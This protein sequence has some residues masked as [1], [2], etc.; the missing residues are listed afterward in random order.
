[1]V[2]TIQRYLFL[3]LSALFISSSAFANNVAVSNVTMTGQDASND[4]V[5]VEFDTSWENSWRTSSAPNNWDAVWVFV[6]YK[7]GSGDWQHA[8]LSATASQH[9]APS[10][11]TI[12]PS[13]DG[14]GA[15]IYR[16]ADG[17]GTVS[18]SDAR[19]RWNY[20]TD[21]VADDAQVTLNAI[22]TEMVY[23]PQGSFSLGSGGV[24]TSEF[25]QYPTTPGTYAVSSENVITVGSNTNNL[26]YSS[27]ASGGDRLGTITAAFPKGYNAFYC[28]KYAI[29]QEQ[30]VDFLKTLDRT[31]QNT[32]TGT[33]LASGITSVTNRYVVSNTSSMVYRNGIR[34]DATIPA[35]GTITFYCDY[36]GNGIGGD[37]DD[38]LAIACNCLSWAD[39]A[40][41]ADWAALRPMTELEF[42]KAC[43]GTAATVADEYA[44]GS[45]SITQATGITNSGAGN[46]MASNSSAN[47]V[48]ESHASVQGPMRVGCFATSNSTRETAGATYY[49]IMEMSGNLVQ[50]CVTIGNV[51][52]RSFTGSHGDGV[53]DST[54]NADA[55]SWPSASASGT[56]YRGGDWLSDATFAR[57]SDRTYASYQNDMRFSTFGF[58]CVRL[59][60]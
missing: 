9:T 7:V 23:V 50:R 40:A 12:T 44:W 6:K 41:Y 8:T 54:G 38:G 18:L 42:E 1:M 53:L 37:F 13:S 43:R 29:T 57:V 28:M 19:L 16:S 3:A 20:G 49:G 17:S 34:C 47:S 46:E 35:T 48:Y 58:R 5:L 30:Y 27:S 14:K 21:G 24:G 15:F 36:N 33:N 59:A 11:S 4:Y 10:G 55:G 51:D 56:G 32:R 31:Q 45:T 26:Y 52:G 22:A 39:G 60:P 25:Y 2:T